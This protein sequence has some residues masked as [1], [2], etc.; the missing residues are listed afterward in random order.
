MMKVIQIELIDPK[1]RIL[2]DDLVRQKII[3]IQEDETPQDQFLSLLSRLRSKD[4]DAPSLEDITKE[5]EIVRTKRL[6]NNG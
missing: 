4:L 3:R 5:V 6:S 2:L 1:A